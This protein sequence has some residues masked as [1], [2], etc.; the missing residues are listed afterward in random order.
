M[1]SDIT[2]VVTGVHSGI[3]PVAV[4]AREIK[5]QPQPAPFFPLLSTPSHPGQTLLLPHFCP[6]YLGPGHSSL[7]SLSLATGQRLMGLSLHPQALQRGIALPGLLPSLEQVQELWGN[8]FG[9]H[10]RV[11]W[12]M[13]TSKRVTVSGSLRLP[14]MVHGTGPSLSHPCPI[15]SITL[16]AQILCNTGA[17]A[18]TSSAFFKIKYMA[19]LAEK[20]NKLISKT[21]ENAEG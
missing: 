12:G 13:R 14:G 19:F 3:I 18:Q 17:S 10:C 1:N 2:L 20:S 21:L 9:L 5:K 15:P 4:A 8:S 11:S 7:V 16:T 6:P